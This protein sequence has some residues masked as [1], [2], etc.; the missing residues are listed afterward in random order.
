M[1]R[2]FGV[3]ETPGLAQRGMNFDRTRFGKVYATADDPTTP[4]GAAPGSEAPKLKSPSQVLAYE[5]VDGVPVISFQEGIKL[6][7]GEIDY[8]KMKETI[9]EWT[10]GSPAIVLNFENCTEVD[11]SSLRRMLFG[12]RT[13]GTEPVL[14]NI[15]VAY[16]TSAGL[17]K[18]EV[19]GEGDPV[20][21]FHYFDSQ[22]K[23]VNLARTIQDRQE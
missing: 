20:D 21:L 12:L 13:S 14:C 19:E 4:A 22:N 6:H 15:D 17:A 1:N 7:F 3:G 2:I 23:A 9:K 11:P 10:K 16:L 18:V 8:A 5:I